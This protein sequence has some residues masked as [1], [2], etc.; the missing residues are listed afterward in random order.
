MGVR[1]GKWGSNDVLE[2]TQR[3]GHRPNRE[4]GQFR[5]LVKDTS[6]ELKRQTDHRLGDSVGHTRD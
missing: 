4:I 2:R 3:S 1:E 5:L 6:K